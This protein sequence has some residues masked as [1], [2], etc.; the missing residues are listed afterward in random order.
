MPVRN[1]IGKIFVYIYALTE[2]GGE[3]VASY[4]ST[5]VLLSYSNVQDFE[6][7]TV[8]NGFLQGGFFS[9][10]LFAVQFVV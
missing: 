1:L 10:F 6:R 4:T 5:N 9:Q 8:T 2:T 7:E 3:N